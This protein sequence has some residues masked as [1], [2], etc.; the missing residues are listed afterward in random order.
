[1]VKNWRELF[2]SIRIRLSGYALVTGMIILTIVC[3]AV[4]WQYHFYAQQWVLEDQL[5]QQFLK[6]AAHNLMNNK[7]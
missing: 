2:S 5:A 6:E 1:M 4:V 7:K 3:L